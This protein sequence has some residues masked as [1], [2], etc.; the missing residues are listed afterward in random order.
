MKEIIIVVLAIV[1]AYGIA[2]N[3]FGLPVP[4]WRRKD[5][6]DLTIPDYNTLKIRSISELDE[7]DKSRLKKEYVEFVAEVERLATIDRA[8][9]IAEIEKY[10]GNC[11]VCKST[12]VGTRI[13]MSSKTDGYGRYQST[14]SVKTVIN[15]CQSC[16]N[17]WIQKDLNNT[18]TTSVFDIAENIVRLLRHHHDAVHETKFDPNRL[19]NKFAT[20]EE[21][22]DNNIKKVK[23]NYFFQITHKYIE[24]R[25]VELIKYL[26]EEVCSDSYRIDD[27]KVYDKAPLLDWGMKQL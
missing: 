12:T 26:I 16:D 6:D 23:E 18:N 25:S 24:G 2:A 10:N 14:T 19:D 11:P 21:T 4:R 22:R 5:K 27:W 20:F 17:E 3:N 15:K 13:E 9:Q 7:Y 8:A 1:T